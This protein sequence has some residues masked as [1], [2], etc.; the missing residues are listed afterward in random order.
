MHTIKN[1]YKGFVCLNCSSYMAGLRDVWHTSALSTTDESLKE[2]TP[3]VYNDGKVEFVAYRSELGL[4]LERCIRAGA[5]VT[6]G[7]GPF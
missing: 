7:G 4:A 6:Q 5:K 3:Q 2:F 1:R